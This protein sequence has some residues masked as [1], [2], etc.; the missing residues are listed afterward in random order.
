MKKDR[1]L[2]YFGINKANNSVKIATSMQNIAE[3]IGVCATTISRK[4][5]HIPWYENDEYIV[6]K[7]TGIQ[8]IKRGFGRVK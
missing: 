2:Y 5:V 4:L 8:H 3:H 6:G 1:K 7:T